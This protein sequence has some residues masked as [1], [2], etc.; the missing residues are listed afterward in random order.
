MFGAGISVGTSGIGPQG[1]AGSQG[2]SSAAGAQGNQGFQGFQGLGGA[3]G[4]QG[5]QGAQGSGNWS[6]LDLPSLVAWFD[7]SDTA[8]IT[9]SGGAVSQWDD[10]SGNGYH[11]TSS[12]TRKPMTG[13]RTQ[14]GLNVLDFDGSNDD[15]LNASVNFSQPTTQFVVAIV[16]ASDEVRSITDGASGR[17][18]I[19]IGKVG[20]TEDNIYA[21][22]QLFAGSGA[23]VG[24]WVAIS[25]VFNGGSSQFWRDGT[26][27]ASGSAG[28]QALTQLYVMSNR[29]AGGSFFTDGGLAEVII[30]DSALSDGDRESVEAYL[31][32]KWGTP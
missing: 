1:A 28:S 19:V 31:A 6:P 4:S 11:L 25:A 18:S 7:A 32:T 29:G 30:Y 2:D 10:K 24:A 22:T 15:M 8:T 27:A 17:Q 26:S 14:N 16:D 23:T 3:Q 9:E 13:T 21:G 20:A 12:G 5:A